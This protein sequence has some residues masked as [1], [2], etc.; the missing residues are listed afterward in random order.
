MSS[1]NDKT[2]RLAG[3]MGWPVA[4]SRSPLL[5]NH[6]IK[7]YGLNGA[8][9]LLPVAPE[10]LH[11]ALRGLP[12]LGFVG[13]NVT[14]P[15]KIE[16]LK[17]V[18]RVDATALRIGAVN[19]IVVEADGSL[20]GFNTDGLGYLQSLRDAMP[21][22][23]ADA[24]PAVVLGAGG[25]A[26]AVLVSLVEQGAREIRL[27]NRTDA[28]AVELAN[29]IGAPITALPWAQR[30]DALAGCALLVNTTSQGM[31]GQQ[32]LDLLLHALPQTALVSD[33]VYVPMLTP[34]L[35]AAQ[36]RG[37]PCAGGLGMLMNQASLAFNKWFGVLPQVSPALRAAVVAS[38]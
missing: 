10:R 13:C 22:W 29:E 36:A 38:L 9:V 34:L 31:H 11:D 2:F 14:L 15:H 16:A 6:W 25:A 18:D 30:H 7:Q 3:V 28:R 8:Y 5:H 23:H 20:S 21:T 24:G 17:R 12:A 26:R 32:A 19:T 27:L 37:N 35:A 33:V 4:H 1:I